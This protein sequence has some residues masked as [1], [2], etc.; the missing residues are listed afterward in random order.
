MSQSYSYP[1]ARIYGGCTHSKQ[2]EK[3]PGSGVGPLT[4]PVPKPPFMPIPDSSGPATSSGYPYTVTGTPS[5]GT[6]A[7]GYP[8]HGQTYPQ[9]TGYPQY[10]GHGVY[11]QTAN[12]STQSSYPSQ[13]TTYPQ[14]NT[15]T[16]STANGSLGTNA[17]YN[18][19]YPASYPQQ[20]GTQQNT[21]YYPS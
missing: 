19:T 7:F 5:T 16:T 15:A 3:A 21:Y 9:N 20:S 2:T 4:P 12:P 18:P 6:Q 1:S 10:T 17:A 11:T 8:S 13:S 14:Y